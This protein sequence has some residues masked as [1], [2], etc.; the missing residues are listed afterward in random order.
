MVWVRASGFCYTVD[1]VPLPRILSYNLLLSRV[2]EI[3][4]PWFHRTGPFTYS[5]SSRKEYV[6]G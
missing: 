4:W 3:L 5:R 6:L 1:T 2:I